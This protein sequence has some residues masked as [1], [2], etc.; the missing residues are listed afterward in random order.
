MKQL[1]VLLAALVLAGAGSAASADDEYGGPGDGQ[2]YLI[3]DSLQIS[4]LCL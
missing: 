1:L 3:P 4:Q 2:F